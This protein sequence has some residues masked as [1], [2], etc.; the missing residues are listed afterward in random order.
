MLSY[1]LFRRIYITKSKYLKGV[2]IK[3]VRILFRRNTRTI[4]LSVVLAQLANQ[5]L[6]IV[7]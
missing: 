6:E 2:L 7:D 3:M 5:L 1:L 4:I